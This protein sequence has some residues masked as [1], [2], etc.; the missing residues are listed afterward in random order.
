MLTLHL[1]ESFQ[2]QA[3]D[4]AVRLLELLQTAHQRVCNLE[5]VFV[6]GPPPSLIFIERSF[7]LADGGNH[8]LRIVDQGL[9]LVGDLLHVAFQGTR[10]NIE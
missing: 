2:M 10:Q 8:F 1:L 3:L 7:H 9:F 4:V 6:I 5:I